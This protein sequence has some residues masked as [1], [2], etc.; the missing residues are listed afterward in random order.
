MSDTL[1]LGIYQILL[2][3]RGIIKTLGWFFSFLLLVLHR[4]LDYQI[5]SP[6]EDNVKNN[7]NVKGKRLWNMKKI[8]QDIGTC[9]IKTQIMQ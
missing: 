8:S 6:V 4:F 9:N 7:K 2:R 3:S 5:C 1:L